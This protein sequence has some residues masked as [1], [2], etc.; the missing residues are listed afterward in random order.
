MGT[1]RAPRACSPGEIQS[2][3]TSENERFIKVDTGYSAMVLVQSAVVLYALTK[4]MPPRGNF[5]VLIPVRARCACDRDQHH[6]DMPPTT[7]LCSHVHCQCS[8]PSLL[9]H[10]VAIAINVVYVCAQG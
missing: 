4:R 6:D 8:H 2:D 5:L 9:Y 3:V 10:G 1:L 7:L